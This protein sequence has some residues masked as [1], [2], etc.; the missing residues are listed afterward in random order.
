MSIEEESVRE[1]L[2]SLNNKL[3]VVSGKVEIYSDRGDGIPQEQAVKLYQTIES[4]T[5]LVQKFREENALD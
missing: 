2:H 4:I 3:T 1:F 5:Q